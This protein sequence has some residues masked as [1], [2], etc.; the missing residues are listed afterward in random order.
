MH[1]IS[2]FSACLAAEEALDQSLADVEGFLLC[3]L[4][5]GYFAAC[6]FC[7]FLI[8]L[9]RPCKRTCFKTWAGFATAFGPPAAG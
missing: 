5:V 8:L 9:Y 4:Y 2:I 6:G 7:P 1:L 3:A